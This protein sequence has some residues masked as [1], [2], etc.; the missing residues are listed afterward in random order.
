MIHSGP[1]PFTRGALPRK[2]VAMLRLGRLAS[3]SVL[4]L[5]CL[6]TAEA[7]ADEIDPAEAACGK[8]GDECKLDGKD[9]TCV[10][11]TCTKLDYSSMGDKGGGPS[12]RKYDC[13]KCVPG[14]KPQ[15]SASGQ[16]G[17]SGCTVGSTTS[18]TS[19]ALGLLLLVVVARRRA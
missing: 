1:P 15:G 7:R 17:G 4:A 2:M 19:F 10:K 18:M 11:A 8:V 12:T 9:G 14:S 16:S 13:A 6:T 3:L 5:L